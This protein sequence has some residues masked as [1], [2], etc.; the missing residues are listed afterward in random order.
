MR[1]LDLARQF[2]LKEIVCVQHKPRSRILP[3][4][5]VSKFQ[6]RYSSFKNFVSVDPATHKFNLIVPFDYFVRS[7]IQIA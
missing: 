1:L 4:V 6:F 2:S 3:N 5:S 7:F